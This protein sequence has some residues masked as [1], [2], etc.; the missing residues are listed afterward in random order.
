[1]VSN[2]M[3]NDYD[4][5]INLVGVNVKMIND[6]KKD[7]PIVMTALG[8]FEIT[9]YCCEKYRHICGMGTGKAYN[10]YDAIPGIT[11]AADL[12]KY[13]LGTNLYVESVGIVTVTDKGGSAVKGNHLDVVFKTHAEALKFGKKNLNVWILK[14]NKSYAT[15]K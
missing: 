8:K 13:P 9:A 10:G 12:T 7:M 11:C 4:E 14:E 15:T 2:A 5:K 1:M 6:V 3:V